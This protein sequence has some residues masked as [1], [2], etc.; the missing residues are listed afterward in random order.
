MGKNV[1][2]NTWFNRLIWSTVA[3]LR[4]GLTTSRPSSTTGDE[5]DDDDA[6][7]E[8]EDVDNVEGDRAVE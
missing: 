4:F 1:W 8:D 5:F 6:D 2:S 7:D 3:R